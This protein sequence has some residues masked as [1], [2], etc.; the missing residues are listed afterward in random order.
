MAKIIEQTLSYFLPPFLR[1]IPL[2]SATE[3]MGCMGDAFC[4]GSHTG[5]LVDLGWEWD[6]SIGPP[7]RVNSTL[8]CIQ[9]AQASIWFYALGR[10]FNLLFDKEFEWTNAHV[11]MMFEIATCVL[12][13]AIGMDS[14]ITA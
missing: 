12:K 5:I 13:D 9:S 3:K 11:H 1:P 6:V 14:S 4:E 2:R 7:K 8:L 10:F